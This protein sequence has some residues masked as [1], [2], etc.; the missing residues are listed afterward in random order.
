MSGQEGLEALERRVIAAIYDASVSRAS[1][2]FDW[3]ECHKRACQ[4]RHGSVESA[5]T[6]I[7]IRIAEAVRSELRYR[8]TTQPDVAEDG[9][10]PEMAAAMTLATLLGRYTSGTTG[11]AGT[12]LGAARLMLEAYPDLVSVF[13]AAPGEVAS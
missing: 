10:S 1:V 9:D 8:S 5:F 4:G 12:Y 2:E 13:A 3:P 11:R 7:Q 6:T